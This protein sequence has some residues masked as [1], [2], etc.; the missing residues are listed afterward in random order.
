MS[1]GYDLY[2]SLPSES[3]TLKNCLIWLSAIGKAIP[4]YSCER[5]GESVAVITG[6]TW[7]L[8]AQMGTLLELYKFPQLTYGTF[9]PFL[10]ENNQFPSVYTMAPTDASLPIGMVLLLLHFHWI[11]VGLV[12]SED[13][14]GTRFVPE[15]RGE[16][17][18]NGVCVEFVEMI[19]V[20]ER[21]NPIQDWNYILK[22][23]D[24]SVSVV[25]IYGDTDS[26]LGLN[27]DRW[28]YV[29]TRK[30]WI[31]TSQWDFTSSERLTMFDTFHGTLSFSPH[32]REIPGF[33]HFLQ[34][35]N[36]SKYPEDFYL[37]KLW[38]MHFDCTIS[39]YDCDKL[40]ACIANA[41]LESLPLH[42]FDTAMSEWSYYVYNAVYA[43]AQSLHE[44]LLLSVESQSMGI[45]NNFKFQ[46]WQLHS[47]LKNVHF[48]NSAGEQIFLDD[49]RISEATY[50]IL[51]YV[52]F[53]HGIRLQVKVGQFVP[54]SP[55]G[56]SLSIN[57][58]VIEWAI[59]FKEMF[60]VK[61][62]IPVPVKPENL[63]FEEVKIDFLILLVVENAV[64]AKT[65]SV[66]LAF[67]ATTPGRRMRQWLASGAPNSVIP[68]CSLIQLTLCGLWLGT[69]P[70]FIDRDTHSKPG[71]IIIECNKGSVTAFYCVLGCPGALAL[72]SFTLA[73]LA[74]NLPDAFNEAKLL[75]FSMLVFCSVWVIFLSVYYSSKGKVMVA[76]E[77]FSIWPPVLGSWAASL[78]PSATL[79]C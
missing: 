72:G 54:R 24:S 77:V 66:I 18:R 38:L 65:F 44:M 29:V 7:S 4:N 26:L 59:G 73:F 58:E 21:S 5:E 39:E 48:N 12:A 15:L 53:P 6:I 8:S 67:K 49:K 33:K 28:T 25:I 35:V 63:Y 61:K 78:F 68:T 45:G 42:E 47:I 52:S 64:L 32:H 31:T 2:N 10:H 75:T 55:H 40:E 69:Y 30:V 46:P 70:P 34:T 50:D 23:K 51:N 62:E 14:K 79:Y 27:F 19:S 11:W 74:R 37:S 57:E 17:D 13:M 16:M 71:S 22:I 9:E 60:L 3:K 76:M 1:L 56:H 36:P 20:T 41:S 43:L